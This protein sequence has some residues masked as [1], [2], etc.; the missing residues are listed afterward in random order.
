MVFIETSTFAKQL[1]SH[2]DD[3]NYAALQAFLAV[4][5]DAGNVIRGTGGIR[6]IRWAMP[7]RGKRGGSRVIYYWL[8]E[9][10]Y[11]S[12]LTVYAKGVKDDLTA[13]E[14]EAWRKAVKAID[15]D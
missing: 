7:G 1:P 5:P 13:A 15:N 8:A 10:D 12:L 9:H 14:R 11:I 4:H 2:L 6:K 3:D